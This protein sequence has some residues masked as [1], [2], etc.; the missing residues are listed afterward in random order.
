MI[1]AT[2]REM[3]VSTIATIP[4]SR[5]TNV[6]T[7]LFNGSANQTSPATVPNWSSAI[8]NLVSIYPDFLGP[9]AYLL[10]FLIPF[11]MMW[12]AHGNMKLL[13]IL[14]FITGVFVFAFLPANFTAA[15]ILCMGVSLAGAIWGVF[16]Q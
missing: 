9:I 11:G 1:L 14:G 10:I 16:K 6:T 8:V 3:A 2:A 15:A 5:Y 7:L 4:Q 13:G 12:M